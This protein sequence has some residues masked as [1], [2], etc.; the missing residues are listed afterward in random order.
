MERLIALLTFTTITLLALWLCELIARRQA[1]ARADLLRAHLDDAISTELD[2]HE[3]IER[4]NAA[5]RSALNACNAAN[6]RAATAISS[7]RALPAITARTKLP[8][9]LVHTVPFNPN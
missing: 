6:A 1:D 5:L 8:A 7:L 9:D 4:L 2:Q 3:E